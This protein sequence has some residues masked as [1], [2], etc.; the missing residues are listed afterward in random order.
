MRRLTRSVRARGLLALVVALVVA[1]LPAQDVSAASARRLHVG[2]SV[3]SVLATDGPDA[4]VANTGTASVIELNVR[5]GKEIRNVGGPHFQLYDPDAIV[6][7]GGDVWV[8]NASSDSLTVFTAR[9]GRLVKVLS[10]SKSHFGEPLGLVVAGRRAFVLGRDGTVVVEIDTTSLRDVR[11]LRGAAY[12]FDHATALVLCGRDV[13]VLST[14]HG[15]ALTELSAT[16]GAIVRVVGAR[17]ARLDDPTSIAASGDDLWVGNGAGNHVSIVDSS[18][19]Q[20][21]GALSVKGLDL[22]GVSSMVGT[23]GRLWLADASQ[24][25]WVAVV[26]LRDRKV[27]GE[28]SRR[29]GYPSVYAGDRMVFV[30]DRT[31]SRVTEFVPTTAKVVRVILD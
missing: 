2:I 28:F 14:G 30:V 15:G 26:R 18:N 5:T 13:W 24:H 7:S 11:V 12:H 4:W 29:F 10:G 27:V 31:E 9:H 25:A 21:A 8:A 3:P 16:T 6:A 19:G 22:D 1:S 17:R 23:D 20:L